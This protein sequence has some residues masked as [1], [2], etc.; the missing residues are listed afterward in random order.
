MLM[1][2]LHIHSIMSGHAFCT[3]NEC[4]AAAQKKGLSLIA[5]TDHGPSMENSAHEGYFEMASRVPKKIGDLKVLFGCEANVIKTNGDIDLSIKTMLGLDIVLAGLHA[6]TP[7]AGTTVK[8]NTTALINAIKKNPTINVITHP[9]RAEFPVSIEEVTFASMEY[10]VLLE[11]NVPTLLRAITRPKIKENFDV[12]CE[13][14]K[15]V[16]ILQKKNKGYIIGSDAHYSTEIGICDSTCGVLF[17]AL[18]ILPEYVLNNKF[19]KLVKY[20]PSVKD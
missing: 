12:I 10:D 4:I 13:T 11:I 6:R 5:I 8:E 9:Y 15:M 20:I 7:Y 18:G 2:D 14:A 17:D 1:T 3:I 19:E 16:D